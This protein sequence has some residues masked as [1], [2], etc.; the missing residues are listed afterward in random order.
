MGQNLLHALK[1]KKS[2]TF[3]PPK[4]LWLTSPRT[5]KFSIT[6]SMVT[7]GCFL[8][9]SF[10]LFAFQKGQMRKTEKVQKEKKKKSLSPSTL[11]F[12]L[13]CSLFSILQREMASSM[14]WPLVLLFL[15]GLFALPVSGGF[16]WVCLFLPVFLFFFF[17][18]ESFFF[19]FRIL[20]RR[21]LR[22]PSVE[23]T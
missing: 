20:L 1:I 15:L 11:S 8:F 2:R 4:S 14:P 23:M 22:K 19:L 17:F 7:F 12:L 3:Q 9:F 21:S 6:C 10:V 16:F 18:A 13:S 5:M